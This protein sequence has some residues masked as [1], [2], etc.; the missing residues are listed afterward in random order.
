MSTC[1]GPYRARRV[2]RE[3]V[4]ISV[5]SHVVDHQCT[6][7]HDKAGKVLVTQDNSAGVEDAIIGLKEA[8]GRQYDEVET[9]PPHGD[10][11]AGIDW[12]TRLLEESHTWPKQDGVVVECI[13]A[14]KTSRLT[15]TMSCNLPAA[16]R[17]SADKNRST[18]QAPD[19]D[20]PTRATQY[21]FSAP[22]DGSLISIAQ[23]QVHLRVSVGD[24]TSVK[25]GATFNEVVS[26]GKDIPDDVLNS[27]DVRVISN[28]ETYVTMPLRTLIMDGALVQLPDG[29]EGTHVIEVWLL[30]TGRSSGVPHLTGGQPAEE[31]PYL[32]HGIVTFE[33]FPRETYMLQRRC[34][35]A[36]LLSV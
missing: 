32:A 15:F 28:R 24:D 9:H 27:Q 14:G 10:E 1:N 22:Q 30:G 2:Y 23:G 35:S 18:S 17:D 13:S 4:D 5:W 12:W 21:V 31:W 8:W 7:L 26:N 16:K 6:L 34:V 20:I 11:Y 29:V 36:E 25:Q 33:A 3:P 19:G